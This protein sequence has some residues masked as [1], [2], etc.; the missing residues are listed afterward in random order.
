MQRMWQPAKEKP[1]STDDITLARPFTTASSPDRYDVDDEAIGL[2][3]W[4]M[5]L[6]PFDLLIRK[7]AH[8]PI[9]WE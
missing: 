9:G 4:S 5:A 2:L 7:C 1:G 6:S 3:Q 8:E